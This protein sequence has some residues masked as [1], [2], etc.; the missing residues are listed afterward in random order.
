MLGNE[1]LRVETAM[2]N[3]GG[4]NRM[5]FLRTYSQP[6]PPYG[7]DKEWHCHLFIRVSTRIQYL[8]EDS[9]QTIQQ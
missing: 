4:K 8:Q 2:R 3:D 9:K 5:H 6:M 1:D 7:H